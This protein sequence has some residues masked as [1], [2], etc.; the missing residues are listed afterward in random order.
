VQPETPKPAKAKKNVAVETPAKP[1]P[2]APEAAESRPPAKPARRGWFG[3]RTQP[4]DVEPATQAA[5]PAKEKAS[6]ESV[7]A[8]PDN[9]KPARAKRKAA[10]IKADKAEA[11]ASRPAESDAAR[12]PVAPVAAAE[13]QASDKAARDGWSGLRSEPAKSDDAATSEETAKSLVF[14]GRPVEKPAASPG[15]PRDPLL[16]KVAAVKLPAL[17]LVGDPGDETTP[18]ESAPAPASSA[19]ADAPASGSARPT[20]S[21]ASKLTAAGSFDAAADEP[22]ATEEPDAASPDAEDDDPGP[23]TQTI[24]ESRARPE[25]KPGRGPS[26]AFPWLRR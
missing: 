5:V 10:S 14:P 15:L 2:A 24:L 11:A 17:K 1:E 16:A 8:Q 12:A 13:S 3:R 20:A 4:A 23:L 22:D 7:P 9:P 6:P 18:V 25:E 26:R 19:S 21:L